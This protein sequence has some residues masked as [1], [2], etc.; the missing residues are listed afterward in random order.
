[1]V[2]ALTQL[3]ETLAGA[4][5][6]AGASVVRV[7]ARRRVPAS[8]IVWSAAGHVLTAHHVIET[9]EGIKVG[10]DDGREVAATLVGRDP[11]T[12]LAVLKVDATGLAAPSWAEP[13]VLRV[14]HIAL[15]LGR[16]G[17]T[18]RATLGIV[19]AKGGAWRT[20]AGGQVEAYV[21]T[22]AAMYPGFSGGPL[23]D[24]SGKVIGMDT[25]AL[26][27]GNTV[28]MPLPAVRRVVES[29]LSHGKVRRGYLG[30]GTQPVRLPDAYARE[31]GQETGLLVAAVEDGSPAER[32]GVMLGDTIIGLAGERVRH[33]DDLQAQLGGERI[34]SP[35]AVRVL[36]G[37]R[38]QDVTVT[39]GE[40]E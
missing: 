22:D 11:A 1:M 5:A 26:V 12:D 31:A 19:S 25:T 15:A 14:G 10:L 16:P 6:A 18:V 8:G 3:S 24:A 29:L 30:V 21:Q 20:P 2:S 4:V 23:V 28:A 27:P 17:R 37:G 38:L 35:V 32:A 13:E 9:D 7:E 33:L 36:R 39:V 40:R 34:G